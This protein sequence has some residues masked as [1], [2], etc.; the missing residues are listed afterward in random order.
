MHLDLQL[1]R[2]VRR[3]PYLVVL[4][5]GINA[6]A[7][8][9]LY[10]LYNGRRHSEIV[11][12]S[13]PTT[14][15]IFTN[16]S[17]ALQLSTLDRPNDIWVPLALSSCIFGMPA[18]YA[19][20]FARTLP[21][22]LY[23]EEL[24]Y[25][26][27]KLREPHFVNDEHRQTWRDYALSDL[28]FRDR[29]ALLDGWV[30]YKGQAG[31]NFVFHDVKYQKFF[32]PDTW[33]P[34]A[35]MSKLVATAPIQ[36]LTHT[37]RS[38]EVFPTLLVALSPEAYSFQHYLDRVTHIIAQGLHLAAGGTNLYAFTGQPGQKIVREMWAQMGFPESHVLHS[39]LKPVAAETLIFSCRAVLVHPW[40]SLRTL[41]LLGAERTSPSSIRNKV[42]YVSRSDGRTNGGRGV[43]NEEAVL[44]AITKLLTAR[45]KG[46]ELVMFNPD[47]FADVKELF[48]WF[49]ANAL[50]VVGPHGGAMYN[51]R[52]ANRDIF[53]LEFI[54]A[55][56][57]AVMIWEE[58]SLLSQTY[59][60]IIAEPT[61]KNETDM[62][63]DVSDVV[64]LLSQHLGVVGEEPIQKSYPW[65]AKELGF[66]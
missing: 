13:E 20:S 53:V 28:A 11:T 26:D 31:Q 1:R 29:G 38:M 33:A 65:S 30:N 55:N 46:E 41:E 19:P 44:D 57:I 5:S 21:N 2:F 25:P 3:R 64:S 7:I 62:V 8:L 22:V 54:P 16:F 61:A 47:Q 24:L 6:I 48:T 52:W 23:A 18:Y 51:H 10:I 17:N 32:G 12:F 66:R 39:N 35:C 36:P 58:A 40:L 59:A 15:R 27:F 9:S 45:D 50:A 60:A 63:I 56:R 49:A 14:T 34:M 43:V 4:V 37:D 42:V